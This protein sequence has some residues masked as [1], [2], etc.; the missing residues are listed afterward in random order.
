M[1][2]LGLD[3]GTTACKA[4]AFDEDGSALV[5]ASREYP[6]LNPRPGWYELD[7]NQVWAAA[8]ECLREVNGQIGHDPVS[9][10][11]ISCQG[12]AV[13]PIGADGTVLANSPI[14]SDS[15]AAPPA[16]ELIEALGFER[17]YEITGQPAS[18]LFTLPKVMWW[19]AHRPDIFQKAAK[20]LCYGDFAT[21][22]LGLPPTIDYSMAARTMA[23]DIRTLEWSDELL[24]AG[25]LDKERLAAPMPS[26]SVIGEIP[27]S[28]AAELGF[29][30]PVQVVTGGHDQPCAALG[31][32]VIRPGTALYS[33]GTTEALVAVV[34]QPNADLRGQNVPCY[35]HVV[36]DTLIAMS[37]NQTG[38]RLLR[39]YRD[40]LAAAERA[41][42]A[43]QGRDVYDV[44]VEQVDDAPSRLLLMPYFAGSGPLYSDLSATG[45]ILG[46]TFSAKR[47]DIVKA[48]L[49][50]LTYEQ[51]LS[52]R[53]MRD[54]GVDIKHLTA[55]GGGA[56]SDIWLQ[57]KS[58]ITNLPIQ[59]IH[60]SEAASLGTAL[61]AGWATGIYQDLSAAARQC[62]SVRKTFYPRA[63][64]A[65]HYQKQLAIY[66]DIYEALR[67]VYGAMA[68]LHG[69]S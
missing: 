19:Q 22:R 36:P 67:P 37:G 59:V 18:A 51:A 60:T 56:R 52:L 28:L 9:A 54:V 44:I 33:I 62:V 65:R 31:G 55:V 21:A 6:L 46:L 68:D 58:D 43:A 24:A 50:G 45:L 15:R 40:E 49:E 41:L 23:F 4:V 66:A 38:G 47:K 35:P 57:I 17:I 3:I 34:D 25:G 10:L 69:L 14:S 61:L 27:T 42:A 11:A 32:G 20:F 2:L 29:V 16:D 30:R 64:Y 13:T 39:W 12:E 63:D 53:C 1:S 8:S 5:R 26:G 48:I 7:P